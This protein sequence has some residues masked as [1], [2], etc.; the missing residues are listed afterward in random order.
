MHL[1]LAFLAR[2]RNSVTIRLCNDGR[3]ES[4]GRRMGEGVDVSK[5]RRQSRMLSAWYAKQD[6]PNVFQNL[7]GSM[8][9]SKVFRLRFRACARRARCGRWDARSGVVS[10]SNKALITAA[11]VTLIYSDY[12][13][14]V[15]NFYRLNTFFVYLRTRTRRPKRWLC[16]AGIDLWAIAS[17]PVPEHHIRIMASSLISTITASNSH[18][19]SSNTI[20]LSSS[21]S[22]TPIQSSLSQPSLD[23]AEVAFIILAPFLFLTGFTLSCW[24]YSRIID[25]RRAERDAR[26]REEE[27]RR[28]ERERGLAY[29]N[30]P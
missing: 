23:K 12:R 3:A 11:E 17:W 2:H 9:A 28:S 22:T 27:R 14:Y 30:F 29:E 24:L 6:S 7:S 16:L 4:S 13:E 25:R 18:I 5:R 8:W 10:R 19:I 21:S 26:K 15:Y 20:V 1:F